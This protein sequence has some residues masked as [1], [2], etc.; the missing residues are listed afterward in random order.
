MQS[1]RNNRWDGNE[2]MVYC[3]RCS[4]EI[5]SSADV[6]TVLKLP[7]LVA[8]YHIRCYGELAKGASP[9]RT[10]LNGQFIMWF[11]AIVSPLCLVGYFLTTQLIWIVLAAMAPSLRLLSWWL[12]EKAISN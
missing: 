8:A 4:D 1:T 12:V 9:F 2:N 3:S 7:E 6:I 11:M 10:P 5:R